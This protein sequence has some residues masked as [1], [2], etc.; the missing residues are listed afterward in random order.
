MCSFPLCSYKHLHSWVGFGWNAINTLG[1]CWM[2][3]LKYPPA[4]A[5][6]G[7][8]WTLHGITWC[9]LWNASSQEFIPLP[10]VSHTR[11][12]FYTHVKPS[13][14]WK[15]LQMHWSLELLTFQANPIPMQYNRSWK[16]RVIG[17]LLIHCLNQTLWMSS[18]Y[19]PYSASIS[20]TME[21]EVDPANSLD[22]EREMQPR[23]Y[24]QSKLPETITPITQVEK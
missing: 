5:T 2:D 3:S 12:K 11:T 22:R 20:H 21:M 24:I 15:W 7:I 9:Q 14:P 10:E 1:K 8:G 6:G 16:C 18:W 17:V 19:C 13:E 4:R 23:C